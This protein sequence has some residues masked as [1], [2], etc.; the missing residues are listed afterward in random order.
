LRET[1]SVDS[2]KS[3]EISGNEAL[4]RPVAHLTAKAPVSFDATLGLSMAVV[5]VVSRD[6]TL[7]ATVRAELREAGVD[8]MGLET[9]DD[10]GE[11]YRSSG[12]RDRR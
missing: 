7:R 1:K 12:R 8:A 3:S 6:W 10:V 9:A 5:F 11:R 2:S 4:A